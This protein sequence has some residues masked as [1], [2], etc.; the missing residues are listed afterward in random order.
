MPVNSAISQFIG[1]NLGLRVSK[2]NEGLIRTL[3]E[4]TVKCWE[5]SSV[6]RALRVKGE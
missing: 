1:I 5:I 4:R 2:T 6:T 3:P